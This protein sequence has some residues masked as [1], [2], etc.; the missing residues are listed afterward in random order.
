[1]CSIVKFISLNLCPLQTRCVCRII[2]FPMFTVTITSLDRGIWTSYFNDFQCC[3]SSKYTIF[4]EIKLI[5]N[6]IKAL[7]SNF[8]I[9]SIPRK[10]H[11][12]VF[13][14][15]FSNTSYINIKH[16]QIFNVSTMGFLL[17]NNSKGLLLPIMIVGILFIKAIP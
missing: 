13:S 6:C 10:M 1:M 16:P 7:I 8:F 14:Y 9:S 11:L 17:L 15:S 2:L 4:W 12:I 3:I 5:I